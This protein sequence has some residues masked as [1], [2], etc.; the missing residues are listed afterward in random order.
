[1]AAIKVLFLK[2]FTVDIF[3]QN[4]VRAAQTQQFVRYLHSPLILAP[5]GASKGVEFGLCIILFEI[6]ISL[7]APFKSR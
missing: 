3:K 7:K 5:F 1:M 2:L 6:L 4:S